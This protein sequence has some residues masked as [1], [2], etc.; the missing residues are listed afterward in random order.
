MGDRS[1]KCLGVLTQVNQFSR[2]QSVYS[3]SLNNIHFDMI[4]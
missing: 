2:G 4:V 3:K 1:S